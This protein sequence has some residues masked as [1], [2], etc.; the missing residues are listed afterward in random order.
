MTEC[1]C[2]GR[3]VEATVKCP[4]D[5]VQVVLVC[6]DCGRHLRSGRPLR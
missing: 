4:C 3:L 1:N 2:N 5:G 6:G